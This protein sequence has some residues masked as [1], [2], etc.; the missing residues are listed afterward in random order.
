MWITTP[1]GDIFKNVI[2]QSGTNVNGGVHRDIC[3]RG[4][5]LPFIDEK[6][7]HNGYWIPY[8]DIHTTTS[9][10]CSVAILIEVM[11]TMIIERY[12]G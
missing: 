5:F 7:P 12:Y 1:P 9:T 6:Y 2:I 3:L 8:L 11:M 4:E 10:L